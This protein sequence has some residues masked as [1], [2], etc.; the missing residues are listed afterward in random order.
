MERLGRHGAAITGLASPSPY[1][2]D[3]GTAVYPYLETIQASLEPGALRNVANQIGL[4]D[5]VCCR[6]LLEHCHEPVPAMRGLR[7]LVGENG[8]LLVEVPDSTKFIARQDFSFIWEEHLSY[9]TA[10]TFRML[11]IRS[12]FEVLELIR[13][14]GVLE[15]ALI[16]IL[17]PA[18][19]PAPERSTDLEN[20]D[21][22]QAEADAFGDF[23][24]A[25]MSMRTSYQTQLGG[26][27]RSGKKVGL[28]GAG[29]QGMMFIN[30]LGLQDYISIVADDDP[31]KLGLYPAGLA[32]PIQ[33]SDAIIADERVGL[34]LMSVSPSVEAKVRTKLAAFTERGGVITSIFHNEAAALDQAPAS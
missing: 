14:N 31:N 15:D 20:Q 27:V 11:A 19:N 26:I 18:A 23:A 21:S 12:G 10:A 3:D 16:G 9:F 17:R 34:C 32:T 4:A 8:L 29:H 2:L 28:L 13:Y 24:G 22:L 6:Y 33:S 25:F 7:E 1:V 5:M 30:A